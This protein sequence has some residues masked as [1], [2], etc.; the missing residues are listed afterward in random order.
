MNRRRRGGRHELEEH[1]SLPADA[2][3]T[4]IL[5]VSVMLGDGMSEAGITFCHSSLHCPEESFLFLN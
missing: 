3:S 4:E 5:L 1:L 2:H